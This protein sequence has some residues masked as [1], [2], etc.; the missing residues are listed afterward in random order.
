MIEN[1]YA[2]YL[3]G[4]VLEGVNKIDGKMEAWSQTELERE[5]DQDVGVDAKKTQVTRL[6]LVK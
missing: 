5:V 2:K 6:K 3:G 4:E 1:S